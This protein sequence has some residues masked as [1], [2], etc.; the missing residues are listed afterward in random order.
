MP[1]KSGGVLFRRPPISA[2]AKGFEF[3]DRDSGLA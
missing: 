3:V 1:G 2:S